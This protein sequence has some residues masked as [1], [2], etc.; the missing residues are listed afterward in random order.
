[1][2]AWVPSHITGFFAARQQ[3]DPS[4]S[5]SIGCG[6]CLA[7]GAIT[8]VEGA[9]N[10]E[11]FLNGVASK[12]PVTRYVVEKLAKEPV[13]VKTSLKCPSARVSGPAVREP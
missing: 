3:D 13:R 12:A 9:E 2:R 10:T 6:L 1:M 7:L 11:I 5:G 8:S 4:L